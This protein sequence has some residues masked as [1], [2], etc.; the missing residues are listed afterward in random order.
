VYIDAFTLS[1]D[2][3]V[4]FIFKAVD[5][6]NPGE[7]STCPVILPSITPAEYQ[8]MLDDIRSGTLPQL[9][10][11]NVTG[12]MPPTFE[13]PMG[14]TSECTRLVFEIKIAILE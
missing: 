5:E 2:P 1:F 14:D 10:N 3:T 9:D 7:S 11:L 4:R 12:M 8:E 6:T 13:Q